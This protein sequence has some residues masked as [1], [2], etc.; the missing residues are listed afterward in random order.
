MNIFFLNKNPI[1]S[2]KLLKQLSPVRANKV[3]IEAIQA[4]AVLCER[5]N[6]LLPLTKDGDP[7]KTKLASRF[8]K[9]IMEWIECKENLAWLLTYV[10]SINPDHSCLTERNVN[11]IYNL[12]RVLPSKGLSFVNYAKSKV[13]NLDF[14]HRPVFE[15]YNRYLQV[16]LA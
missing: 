4:V 12:I 8:P 5:Y 10:Q 6:L 15:A 3:I 7:Y 14:T 9:P 1:Y 2:A 16:Q 11:C 13:K